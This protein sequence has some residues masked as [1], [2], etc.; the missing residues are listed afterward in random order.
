MMLENSDDLVSDT[1]K[2]GN[3][4]YSY[5]LVDYIRYS[6]H[7]NPSAYPKKINF[8]LRYAVCRSDLTLT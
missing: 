3:Y 1:F 2:L 6:K 7:L 8:F 4:L 5:S